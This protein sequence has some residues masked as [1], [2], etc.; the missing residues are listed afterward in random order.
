MPDLETLLAHRILADPVEGDVH[1]EF[2]TFSD[3][4]R[5][6]L[7]HLLSVGNVNIGAI[8]VSMFELEVHFKRTLLT[9]A[10]AAIGKRAF[11]V[12]PDVASLLP[13]ESLLV[14]AVHEELHA[15]DFLVQLAI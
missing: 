12:P 15:K 10:L 7:L 5:A 9:I 8:V 14:L 13:L 4:V 6:R 1:D 3:L 2:I 11:E